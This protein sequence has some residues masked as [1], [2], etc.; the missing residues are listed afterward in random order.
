M[1]LKS[2]LS[3]EKHT[4][5]YNKFYHFILE[6]RELNSPRFLF[7]TDLKMKGRIKKEKEEIFKKINSER[8]RLWLDINNMHNLFNFSNDICIY[9]MSFIID[10]IIKFSIKKLAINNYYKINFGNFSWLGDRYLWT[11]KENGIFIEELDSLKLNDH[12][13]SSL[14]ENDEYV[15]LRQDRRNNPCTLI[16]RSYTTISKSLFHCRYH[17]RNGICSIYNDLCDY[18]K[19]ISDNIS[20]K[21]RLMNEKEL[22]GNRIVSF[23]R[24][25]LDR[26]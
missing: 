23:M 20:N 19:K 13:K 21:I 2:M 1:S 22:A 17:D 6:M 5:N 9:I 26:S 4:N 11:E 16:R 15:R 12:I 8:T 14:D 10:D 7:S 25:V 18:D 24:R 3:I